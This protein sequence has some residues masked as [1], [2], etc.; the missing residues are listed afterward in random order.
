MRLALRA[1]LGALALAG[2]VIAGAIPAQAAVTLSVGHV[3]VLKPIWVNNTLDLKV[4]DDTGS[5]PVTRDPADVIFRALPGSQ[6]TV[7]TDP[8]FAFLGSPGDPVWIL[9]QTQNTSLLWPGW[10]TDS[11][12]TGVFANNTVQFRL[13]S[14]TPPAGGQVALYSTGSTGAPT[15]IFDSENGLPD[16]AS[17][18]IPQHRHMNWAF[19]ATG[20]YR[21]G[22]E[23]RA[24]R[25]GATITSGVHTYTFTVG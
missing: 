17:A 8:R 22:F 19:E 1:V 4:N 11:L 14:I 6:R 18:T 23:V 10:S 7:P 16:T 15:V 9:P 25:N 5:A 3:D 12:P 2:T 13:V 21:L 24:T 20:T